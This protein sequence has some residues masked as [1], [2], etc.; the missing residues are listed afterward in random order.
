[1]VVE[2]D[3]EILKEKVQQVSVNLSKINEQ[4]CQLISERELL[5]GKVA[6]SNEEQKAF[7]AKMEEL[8]QE[9]NNKLQYMNK[10][11]QLISLN[12]K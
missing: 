3:N 1:M 5:E 8:S 11:E 6:K 9:L 12:N 10:Q 2:K 4:N 7:R